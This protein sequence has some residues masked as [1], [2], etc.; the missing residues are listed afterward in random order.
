VQTRPAILVSSPSWK[1]GAPSKV[2]FADINPF[3]SLLTGGG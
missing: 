3:V 2:D 1:D